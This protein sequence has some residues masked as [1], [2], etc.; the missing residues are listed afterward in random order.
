MVEYLGVAHLP[1]LKQ[2]GFLTA[3]TTVRRKRIEY[4]YRCG[5]LGLKLCDR[6]ETHLKHCRTNPFNP[7]QSSAYVISQLIVQGSKVQ[8]PKKSNKGMKS[9][10]E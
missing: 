5:I 8:C 10:K 7:V 3:I 6:S 9:N 2:G 4:K 1:Y